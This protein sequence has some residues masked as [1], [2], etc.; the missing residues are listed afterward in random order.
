MRWFSCLAL[1][2]LIVT[3]VGAP[4]LARVALIQ[5]MAPLQDHTAHSIRDALEDAV[6]SAVKGAAAMGLSTVK[7]NQALV[8]EDMVTVQIVATDKEPQEQ[9]DQ[10]SE[11]GPSPVP[12]EG[13]GDSFL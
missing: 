13:F 1:G 6:K 8:L 9:D 11:K 2:L 4:A 7:L 12:G 3:S 10:N 5:T